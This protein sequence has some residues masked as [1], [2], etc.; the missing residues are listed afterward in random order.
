MAACPGSPIACSA[1]GGALREAG[2]YEQAIAAYQKAIALLT[3]GKLPPEE[4]RTTFRID[5]QISGCEAQIVLCRHKLEAK[6]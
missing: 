2:K 6:P 5:D 3:A 4:P 1:L